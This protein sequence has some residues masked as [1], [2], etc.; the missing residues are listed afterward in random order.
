MNNKM[1][2][3]LFF[4]AILLFISCQTVSFKSPAG[5]NLKEPQITTLKESLHEISGIS[6]LN[7][8]PDTIYAINDEDGKLFY[9]GLQ[10]KKP[11]YV[12]FGKPGDYEDLTIAENK[13]IILKSD[14]D[15]FAF[16]VQ[17]VNAE[18]ID[19]PVITKGAIPKNEYEGLYADSLNKL[20]V[21]CKNC[22][23][24]KPSMFVKV[25]RLSGN[26]AGNFT[27][28]AIF[29]IDVPSI[30]QLIHEEKL[31]FHPS[32]FAIHPITKQ[33]YILSSVNK[34]LVITDPDFKVKEAYKLKPN[35]FRQPEGIAF[36]KGGNLYVSNEGR[37]EDAD[38]L[39]FKYQPPAR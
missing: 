11:P 1:V 26:P 38:I 39:F 29:H 12:K 33:W 19:S 27:A 16:D 30:K 4:S 24:D 37:D 5:Y 25:Y 34:L 8:K 17:N 13:I 31:S 23:G 2:S 22:K 15:L 9:F 7:N 20:Y 32:A 28:D 14:G 6:F 35:L 10:N 3:G 21:L 18:K 36:D